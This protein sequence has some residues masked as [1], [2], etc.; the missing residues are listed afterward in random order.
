MARPANY[1]LSG[2]ASTPL[3][4]GAYGQWWIRDRARYT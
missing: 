4:Y 1:S 3:A 2:P